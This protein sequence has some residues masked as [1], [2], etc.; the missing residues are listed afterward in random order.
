[1]E[2]IKIYRGDIF[3]ADTNID[4]FSPGIRPIIIISNN[5]NNIHSPI[6]NVIPMVTE[7]NAGRYPSYCDNVRVKIPK[8]VG[9]KEDSIALC[10]ITDTLDKTKLII[11]I[12]TLDYDILYQIEKA[13]IKS[14]DINLDKL[15]AFF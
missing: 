12:G 4:G 11:R 9:L 10:D 5:K 14:H 8:E 13:I 3:L 7:R 15:R 1:M 6:V 2:E